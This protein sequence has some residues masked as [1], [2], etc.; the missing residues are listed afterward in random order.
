[1]LSRVFLS[2]RLRFLFPPTHAE[3]QKQDDESRILSRRAA[4]ILIR[5]I[6]SHHQFLGGKYCIWIV[7]DVKYKHN[8]VEISIP[9]ERLI[10]LRSDPQWR[11]KGYS[12]MWMDSQGQREPHLYLPKLHNTARSGLPGVHKRKPSRVAWFW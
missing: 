3:R 5:K 9:A 12:I 11:H 7:F 4:V 8:Q 6:N 2:M 1:M 10:R